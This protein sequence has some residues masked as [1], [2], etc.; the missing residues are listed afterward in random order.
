MPKCLDRECVNGIRSEN[1]DG[2]IVQKICQ[3][4]ARFE[5][6]LMESKECEVVI[7]NGRAICYN[8]LDEEDDL[9]DRGV[10]TLND[11][12]TGRNSL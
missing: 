5:Q 2:Y 9:E 10:P 6:E 8:I 11:T 1:K 4:C 3:K 12:M 7:S